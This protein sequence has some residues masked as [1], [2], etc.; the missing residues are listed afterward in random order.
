[1]NELKK[2]VAALKEMRQMKNGAYRKAL[3]A[4][5][6]ATT[7]KLIQVPDTDTFRAL[8]REAQVL[9]EMMDC[10]D[11][12]ADMLTKAARSRPDMQKLY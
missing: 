6:R 7:A 4:Q 12:A 11:N 10:I 8:Q 3:E 5:L 1:M 9:Q 2:D